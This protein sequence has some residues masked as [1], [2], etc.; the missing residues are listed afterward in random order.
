[1]TTTSQLQPA[2][3]EASQTKDTS[4]ARR[5]PPKRL[6]VMLILVAGGTAGYFGYQKWKATRPLEWSGTV[7]AHE[8]SVGSRTGG[9]VQEVR[10]HEGEHVDAGTALVILEHGDLDAQR[11]MGEAQLEQAQ[12]AFDKLK[13]GARPEEIAEARARADSA[14]ASLEETQHGARSEQVTAAKARLDQAQATVEKA[15]LDLQR[16]QQLFDAK[17]ISQAELDTASAN[18]RASAAQRDAAKAAL[19][20]LQ[21]GSR[22]EDV[23]MAAHRVEEAKAG[24][25]LIASGARVEDLRA[26]ES[27]VKAAQARVDQLDVTIGELTIKASR[28]ARIETLDLRPGDILAPM[29]TAAVLLEDDQLYVRIYV[30]ETQLGYAHPDQHVPVYVDTFPNRAFDGVIAHIDKEGQYS[31]RNLQTAD[32]RANQVFAMRVEL[33]GDH[34]DLRAGMAALIRVKR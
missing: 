20:E 19:S 9:R 7:E 22:R 24:A 31:P 15:Q 23:A 30:P 1:V 4:A 3:V 5:G 29:A 16:N 21:N 6:I 18:Y 33:S 25:D 10:V 28:P 32:E 26:A 12:A 17:A 13:N 34:E 27:Q 11:L 8:V 2:Q 14:Q